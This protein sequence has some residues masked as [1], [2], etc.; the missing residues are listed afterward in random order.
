MV[1]AT[2]FKT[3]QKD[4]YQPET[5]PCVVD[6]PPMVFIAVDGQGDPN[7]SQEYAA[8]IET[9]YGLS[10]TIKMSNKSVMDY[11]VGP[12]EGLWWV[13]DDGEDSVAHPTDKSTFSW[14]AMI[15]Q[16]DFVTN[17]VF[18]SARDILAK[19]RPKIDTSMARLVTVT[20]GL[21]VQLLHVGPY[22]D[23]WSSVELLNDFAAG[24]GYAIDYSQTRRHHEI[25]LSDPRRVAPDKLQTVIRLPVRKA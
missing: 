24:N 23:E 15:R 18:A 5:A 20:E 17:A 19:R 9:L 4:L 2:D 10:Y 25:Y 14:T 6:V 7:T 11:V 22:D 13:A 8:A 3:L 21:C 12:L 1:M 16:P